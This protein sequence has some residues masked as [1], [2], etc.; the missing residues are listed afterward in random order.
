MNL[1]KVPM[2]VGGGATRKVSLE[3]GVQVWQPIEQTAAQKQ[4]LELKTT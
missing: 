1:G 2:K 3:Q 4:D